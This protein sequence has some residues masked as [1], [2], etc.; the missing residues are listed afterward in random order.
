MLEGLKQFEKSTLSNATL[1]EL[2]NFVNP[3]RQVL[4]FHPMLRTL[5]DERSTII[6]FLKKTSTNLNLISNS[7]LATTS[8]FSTNRLANSKVARAPKVSDS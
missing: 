6:E 4:P 5:L 2:V 1:A 3:Y 7:S 8:W